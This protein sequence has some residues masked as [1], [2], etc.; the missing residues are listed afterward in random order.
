MANRRAP[1]R[2]EARSAAGIMIKD[3]AYWCSWADQLWHKCR[4]DCNWTDDDFSKEMA[5]NESIRNEAR[6]EF[7]AKQTHEDWL[8]I[9]D[10]W[11]SNVA[12]GVTWWDE[13]HEEGEV[14]RTKKLRDAALEQHEAEEREEQAAAGSDELACSGC[15]ALEGCADDVVNGKVSFLD[16]RFTPSPLMYVLCF[17]FVECVT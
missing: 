3:H 11:K 16:H 15:G 7:E 6:D 9:L 8:G 12:E 10:R 13:K 17:R 4:D 5:K 1:N 2:D 14:E